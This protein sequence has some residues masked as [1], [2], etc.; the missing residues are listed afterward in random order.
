MV[1]STDLT[2]LSPEEINAIMSQEISR[3]QHRYQVAD[4]LRAARTGE[5]QADIN[6]EANVTA[7]RNAAVNEYNAITTRWDT[8]K[9]Y[10]GQDKD[11]LLDKFKAE[12]LDRYYKGHIRNLDNEHSRKLAELDLNIAKE[13]TDHEYKKSV[14][15]GN[16]SQSILY[17]AQANLIS[18][19]LEAMK[20]M[21][22]GNPLPGD[23]AI[24]KAKPDSAMS[25]SEKR[26]RSVNELKANNAIM[27][28]GLN[29]PNV[30]QKLVHVQFLRENYPLLDYS[31]VRPRGYFGN[32]SNDFVKVQ[33]PPGLT[34]VDI[35]GIANTNGVSVDDVLEGIY[36]ESLKKEK[37]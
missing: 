21:N 7:S 1:P 18:A 37:K 27:D 8:V 33:L 35:Q 10:Q 11:R 34:M 16:E 32:Q 20:R 3:D 26:L 29:A 13:I 24:L 25:D 12:S 17:R 14:A 23:Q 2:G 9:K 5:V 31:W 22:E 28:K 36:A 19:Q 30:E 4:L 15:D 6:R